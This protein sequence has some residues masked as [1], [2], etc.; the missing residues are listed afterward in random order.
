M[1]QEERNRMF[2]NK[3]ADFELVKSI[4]RGAHSSVYEVKSRKDPNASHFALKV[5]DKVMVRK[6]NLTN[7]LVNEIQIHSKI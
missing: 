5:V 1:D 3:I 4:G 7:R 6:S 2:G